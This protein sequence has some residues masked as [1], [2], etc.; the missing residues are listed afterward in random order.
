MTA[1]FNGRLQVHLDFGAAEEPI[2]L[3]ECVWY[4]RDQV[5]A[6]QWSDRSLALPFKLSLHMP[7]NKPVVFAR[8]D[9]F[10]GIHSLLSDSIPDGFGLRM[11]N[12]ALKAAGHSLDTVTPI[13]RLAWVG[14]RGI[15]A[16]T[17]APAISSGDTN[18]LTGIAALGAHA[19][20][21]DLD[22]F[23]DIP[24]TVLMAG[25]SAHG[26]RPK[27]WAAVHKDGKTVMLGDGLHAPKDFTPCLVKFAPARGDK[28]E[29]YFEASCLQLANKHGVP[30]AKARLLTHPA[31]AAL[32]VERFDRSPGGGRVL[33]QSLAA[34]LNDDYRF[35]KLDYEQLF[36]VSKM[37]SE[38]PE[39]ERVYRL[40]CFN[41]ALS[42]KDDHSKNFSFLMDNTGH[43]Q[44]SPAYD[45]CPNEGPS[46]WQTMSVN[47]EANQINRDHLLHFAKKIGL[48][49]TVAND[50]I[51]HALCAA[52]E[53]EE[54]AISLG[55]VKSAT[56]KWSKS[57]KD[58]EKRLAPIRVPVNVP[59]YKKSSVPHSA[60][61]I[62]HLEAISELKVSAQK[63]VLFLKD[64][65]GAQSKGIARKKKD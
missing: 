44:L 49:D 42:M 25:G 4:G 40:A 29:P 26:A 57:F 60:P 55:A 62:G 41:V 14:N 30:A 38:Q 58:I 11:M 47:G 22:N 21:A 33:T 31:G 56:K 46:G 6:F 10:G 53:F 15:G 7:P 13:H 12:N 17:Y 45:L 61:V 9:P 18:E 50:G 8:K 27:F 52:N 28:N 51:D 34:I 65:V 3:G 20:K 63:A 64:A 23:V 2:L 39:A 19:I 54:L 32:A 16:L 24:K 35:P 36:Q 43:W 37:L 1:L 59:T 48:S 5:A